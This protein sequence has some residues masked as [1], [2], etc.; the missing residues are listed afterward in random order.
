MKRAR[1]G[2]ELDERARRVDELVHLERASLALFED[3]AHGGGIIAALRSSRDGRRRAAQRS[4][5]AGAHHA[6]EL[7]ELNADRGAFIGLAQPADDTRDASMSLEEL[8]G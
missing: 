3:L 4:L 1:S 8:L 6:I 7:G 2:R 5:E